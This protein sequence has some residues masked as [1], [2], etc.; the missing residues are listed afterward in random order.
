MIMSYHDLLWYTNGYYMLST[1]FIKLRCSLTGFGLTLVKVL[2]SIYI[3]NN[4]KLKINNSAQS[5][6]R[7]PQ[8]K[9]ICGVSQVFSAEL[10]RADITIAMAL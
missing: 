4:F 10:Y 6:T 3:Y 7:G 8:K 1:L 2:N 9:W 5:H